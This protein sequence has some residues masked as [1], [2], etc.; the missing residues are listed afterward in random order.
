MAAALTAP[1]KDGWSAGTSP[2]AFLSVQVE[3]IARVEEAGER[4]RGPTGTAA[5]DDKRALGLAEFGQGRADGVRVGLQTPRRCRA[6]PVVQH[7][8]LGQVLAQNVGRDFDVGRAG[9][10]QV[11]HGAGDGFVHLTEGLF[12]HA[13]GARAAGH[14]FQDVDVRNVLERPHVGLRTRGAAADEQ[15]RD[16]GERGVRHRGH[17]VG[18]PG[19]GCH[20][21]DADAAGELGVRLGHVHGGA[22]VPDIDDTDAGLG[23]EVPDRLDVAA[24]ETEDAI[25]AAGLQRFGDPGGDA[26]CV[27]VEVLTVEVGGAG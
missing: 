10:A 1:T 2:A 25:D 20:H 6:D 22:L 16:A 27:A 13:C 15:D 8:L 24:L 4:L 21:G 26:Q 9:L 12:R 19:A 18:N 14:R 7:Q 11:A 23:R 3:R 5:A 17:R